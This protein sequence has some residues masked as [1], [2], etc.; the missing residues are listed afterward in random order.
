M[1]KI[2]S[3]DLRRHRCVIERHLSVRLSDS[4]SKCRLVIRAQKRSWN[5]LDPWFPKATQE[6]G[7]RFSKGNF[8]V[9]GA[10]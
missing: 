4:R 1:N 6:L 9:Y 8:K 2:L 10:V 7:L 5:L 3:E